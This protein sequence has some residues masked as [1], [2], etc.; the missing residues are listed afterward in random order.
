MVLEFGLLKREEFDLF[1]LD[2]LFGFGRP[3]LF[4]YLGGG[5]V[6]FRDQGAEQMRVLLLLLQGH[7]LYHLLAVQRI[8]L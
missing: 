4:L 1:E 7:H 3:G 2:N 8:Q 5:A 6:Q